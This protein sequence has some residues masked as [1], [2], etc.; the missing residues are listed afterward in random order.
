MRA[1]LKA[2]V[3]VP[4]AL[5]LVL[6]C[7]ANRKTVTLS[8]DPVSRDIPAIAYDL[9]LFAIVLA[10]LFAGVLIGGC[11]AWLAQGR[12]R[13][14]ERVYRKETQRLQGEADTLRAAVPQATLAALPIRRS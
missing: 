1:L 14:M 11:A 7:V 4:L 13:K 5:A 3:L 12:H 9:P 2:L 8:L 6:F 10:A